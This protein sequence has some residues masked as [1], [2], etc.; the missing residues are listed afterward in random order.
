[1]TPEEL[2]RIVADT[3]LSNEAVRLIL[4]VASKPGEHEIESDELRVVLKC[5]SD[6]PVY[7]ARKRAERLGYIRWKRGGKGHGNVYEYLPPKLES[8]PEQSQTVRVGSRAES[9][10]PSSTTGLDN[11]N[12]PMSPRRSDGLEAAR[13]YMGEI[14]VETALG[15]SVLNRI[16]LIGLLG[17]YGPN[18]T[19]SDRVFTGVSPPDRGKILATAVTRFA[20]EAD[21]Y[22]N[23]VFESYLIRARDGNYDRRPAPERRQ[24]DRG[25]TGRTSPSQSRRPTGT[26]GVNPRRG[27]WMHEGG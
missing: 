17:M 13:E 23:R 20:L 8:V 21:K 19:Q 2:A 10:G 18:G 24:P 27:P 3:E 15:S 16:R 4:F 22:T 14:A 11:N 12:P 9:N 1:M 5:T 25:G 7:G 6:T 26:E